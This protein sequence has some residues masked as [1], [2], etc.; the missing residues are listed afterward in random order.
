MSIGGMKQVF[1]SAFVG[2]F[3]FL[4]A[5][6]LLKW[7][8]FVWPGSVIGGLVGCALAMG[9][10]WFGTFVWVKLKAKK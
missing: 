9:I 1:V 6:W 10:A 8:P 2:S 7:L 3:L 4:C 5:A